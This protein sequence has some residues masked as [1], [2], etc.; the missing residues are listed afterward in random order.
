MTVERVAVVT[1]AGSG[2]GRAAS[3]ALAAA[4]WYV[5]A[6]GRRA[7]PL[8]SLAVDITQADGTDRKG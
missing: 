2:V 1:G 8:D 4:G 6:A 5:V 7:A 3:L